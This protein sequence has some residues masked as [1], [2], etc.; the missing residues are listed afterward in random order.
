MICYISGQTF[1][2]IDNLYM[3]KDNQDPLP[4]PLRPESEASEE[5][6]LY[7]SDEE[8]VVE[9]LA[10]PPTPEV[11]MEEG[12]EDI[13]IYLT[14]EAKYR[15]LPREPDHHHPKPAPRGRPRRRK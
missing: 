14:E 6:E 1:P 10:E 5:E 2:R 15:A 11:K 3:F 12:C 8:S 13:D 9:E 7:F 4:L